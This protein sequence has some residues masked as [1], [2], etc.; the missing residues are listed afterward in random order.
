MTLK[1]SRCFASRSLRAALTFGFAAGLNTALPLQAALTPAQ[2]NG[3]RND[4]GNRVEAATIL[5]GDY[6]VGGGTFNS[7]SG[8]N[9]VD[10]NIS[11]F[12][13]SGDVGSPKP[14]GNL[15]IG[16]QPRLQGSM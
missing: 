7:G 9:N 10:L 16:W 12:G 11:K 1:K 6:G 14:L 3:F 8:P 4:I 13:G 15:D 5:G 2:I